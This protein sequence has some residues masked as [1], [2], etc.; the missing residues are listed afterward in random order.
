MSIE[1]IQLGTFAKRA[2]RTISNAA[3]Y[4]LVQDMASVLDTVPPRLT[5]IENKLDRLMEMLDG[6]KES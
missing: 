6:N 4:D 3:L 1:A 2:S 5:S